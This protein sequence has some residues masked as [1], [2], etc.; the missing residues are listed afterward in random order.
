MRTSSPPTYVYQN[1]FGNY[2]FRIAVPRNLRNSIKKYE[3]RRTLKT[4]DYSTALRRARRLAVL[5]EGLF[6]KENVTEKELREL[7]ITTSQVKMAGP[8]RIENGTLECSG[9]ETDPDRPEEE[10]KVIGKIA[11]YLQLSKGDESQSTL[12]NKLLEKLLESNLSPET[13]IETIDK[14]I[15]GKSSLKAGK[16]TNHNYVHPH[17][18]PGKSITEVRKEF[19]KSKTDTKAWTGRTPSENEAIIKLFEKFFPDILFD[20][21][22][23]AD[24]ERFRDALLMAPTNLTKSNKYNGLTLSQIINTKPETTLA[25]GSVNSNSRIGLKPSNSVIC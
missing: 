18:Y 19:V 16:T 5:A 13:I 2:Y 10:A 22:T 3:I 17:R 4:R 1:G 11:E 12:L 25:V 7:L 14:I 9:I 6:K 21:I 23:D 15:A 20:D 8:V 24:A